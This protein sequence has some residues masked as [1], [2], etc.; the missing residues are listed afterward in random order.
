MD[1]SSIP[2]YTKG[3]AEVEASPLSDAD[4]ELLKKTILLSQDDIDHLRLA[5]E[6]LDD[7]VEAV[8]DVWYGFVGS[9][10]HL[11]KYFSGGDGQPNV[12]YLGAVRKR[13]GQWIRDLCAARYDRVWLD[14]QHELGLRHTRLK[15]N[16]TDGVRSASDV[17]H[18]RYLVAF[19]VPLTVTIRP[20]LARKGHGAEVV[21]KMYHAWFKVLTLTVALWGQAFVPAEDF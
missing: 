9:H 10:P 5:G 3:T 1:T 15:K 21:D 7:Q 8:L 19:I 18:F 13:F 11:L 14:Y 4:F 12:A 16:K 6:V 17:I 2:G 20:F